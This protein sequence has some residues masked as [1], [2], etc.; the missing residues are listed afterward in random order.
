[1]KVIDSAKS[2]KIIAGDVTS[3]NVFKQ[4]E[5]GLLVTSV[6]S[7]VADSLNYQSMV[8]PGG[9]NCS[10]RNEAKTDEVV[11]DVDYSPVS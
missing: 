7:V 5:T 3:V 9:K 10:K 2:V 6:V 8:I 1:M 4:T 11:S